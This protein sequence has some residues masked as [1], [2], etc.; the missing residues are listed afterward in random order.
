[1]DHDLAQNQHLKDK[2]MVSFTSLPKEIRYQIYRELYQKDEPTCF[3]SPQLHVVPVAKPEPHESILDH[4]K[5]SWYPFDPPHKLWGIT[6]SFLRSCRLVIEEATYVLY[7]NTY[8]FKGGAHFVYK[9][10]TMG[11]PS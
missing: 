2:A 6:T 4:I 3:D 11:K 10:D 9:S 8:Y 5:Y 7:A 1:M